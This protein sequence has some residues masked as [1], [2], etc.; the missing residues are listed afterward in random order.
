MSTRIGVVQD[1][2]TLDFTKILEYNCLRNSC[3]SF[4]RLCLMGVQKLLLFLQVT[5]TLYVL[6]SISLLTAEILCRIIYSKR[7][8]AKAD[9]NSIL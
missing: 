1:R 7:N 8:Y 3:F 9:L 4:G 2:K 5:T 6:N